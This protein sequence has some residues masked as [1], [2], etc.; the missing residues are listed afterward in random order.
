MNRR[1]FLGAL[2]MLWASCAN[3]QA[4]LR[5]GKPA[6]VGIYLTSPLATL[7]RHYVQFFK[8]GMR[9]LGWVEDSTVQYLPAYP[10]RELQS[11]VEMSAHA[12]KLVALKPDVIWLAS[13]I[14]AQI[15]VLKV[16]HAIP[17]VGSAVSEVVER[18]LAKSLQRPGGIFTGVSNFSWELGVKRFEILRKM[19]PKLGRVG[20]LIHPANKNC[21]RE[22]KLIQEAAAPVRVQ[23]IAAN[24]ARESDMDAAFAA[25]ARERAEAL[26]IA[27]HP[28]FQVLRKQILKRTAGLKIPAVGHRT[29]FA[30]DGALFAY[31]TNLG[32]Q[33]RGSARLVDKILKGTAPAEIPVEQPT[34]FE[35]V[36]NG[37]TV[38]AFGLTIPDE[39]DVLKDRII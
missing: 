3:A 17:V 36:I 35:L 6:R 4:L 18:G 13:S 33:M 1:Q 7:Q 16:K 12:D 38:K 22:F 34:L 19:M 27:H 32:E 23:V 21:A 2:A 20:V 8:D 37:N 24:M 31:S 11:E 10:E 14:S 29:F 5:T 26:L 15:L 39:V 28:L 9:E 25:L 30:E